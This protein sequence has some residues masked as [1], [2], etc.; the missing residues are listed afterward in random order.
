MRIDVL[1]G[2]NLTLLGRRDPAM[3]GRTRCRSWRRRST[4][5]PATSASRCGAGRRTTRASTSSGSTRR[6]ARPTG[7]C[8][9]RARGRT[10]PGRSATRSSPSRARSSRCTSP[11]STSGRSG[12]GTP[13]S[14]TSAT[15]RVTGK[16]LEGYRE[17]LEHLAKGLRDD[18]AST[19]LA[20]L[21]AML[22]LPLVVTK[23]VNVRYLTGLES[24]NAA[25]VVEPSGETLLLHGLPLCRR[26]PGDRGRHV[27]AGAPSR[28][29]WRRGSRDARS[30]SRRRT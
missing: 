13:S 21:A 25:L 28:R 24:S 12:G 3:Y 16:G 7:S 2:V 23:G 22:D 9:T 1:N 4:P 15:H 17:A 27:R 10:T 20:R 18:A 11:T 30:G 26:G 8:S 19:R 5:G 6:S 29:R 14:P